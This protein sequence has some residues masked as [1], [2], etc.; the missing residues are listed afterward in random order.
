MVKLRTNQPTEQEVN[1]FLNSNADKTYGS[2]PEQPE[3]I[4]RV[5]VSMSSSTYEIADEI[6]RK[7]K[8]AKLPN[9]SLSALFVEALE[10]YLKRIN[11]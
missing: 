7:R 8:R 5:N 3:T 10:D 4:M 11:K 6:V 9:R 2:Q 1:N